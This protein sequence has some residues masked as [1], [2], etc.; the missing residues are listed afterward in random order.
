M[1]E[2]LLYMHKIFG[3]AVHS[4]V[5]M[6]NHFHLLCHTPNGN[7]DQIMQVFLRSTSI[8]INLQAKSINHLWGGKI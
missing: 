7:L 3:L 4:F 5:L 2:Q 8:K 1:M 6:G